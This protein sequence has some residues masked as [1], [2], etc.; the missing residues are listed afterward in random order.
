MVAVEEERRLAK[1]GRHDRRRP[2]ERVIRRVRGDD[3]E[4][5]PAVRT[6]EAIPRASAFRRQPAHTPPTRLPCSP[7]LFR[8]HAR[9]GHFKETVRTVVP[10]HFHH[11][12]AVA[13]YGVAFLTEEEVVQWMEA[14]GRGGQIRRRWVRRS[15]ETWTVVVDRGCHLAQV[16]RG[17]LAV[18]GTVPK[19]LRRAA[20][21]RRER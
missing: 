20:G 1:R 12:T 13:A 14:V 5:I 2:I 19:D 6:Q 17:I 4:G 15:S 21:C 8:A 10:A 16:R 18:V 9:A 7:I 3:G 11:H